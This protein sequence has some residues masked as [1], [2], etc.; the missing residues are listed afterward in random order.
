MFTEA[1]KWF[2]AFEDAKKHAGSDVKPE[3]GDYFS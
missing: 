3:S 2:D 1:K